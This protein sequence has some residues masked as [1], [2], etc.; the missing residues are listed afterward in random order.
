MSKFPGLAKWTTPV[1]T[2]DEHP[3]ALDVIKRDHVSLRNKTVLVTGGSAGIGVETVRAFAY[4]G[5]RVFVLAR[6]VDKARQVLDKI[7]AEFPQHGGL[8]IIQG[9]LDS[10]ASVNDAANDFL[11]RSDQLHI[12]VNNA[13]IY[14]VPFALT[15]D[16]FESQL[17]IDHIAHHLLFKKLV[18][19]LIKSSTPQFQS[20]VIAVASLVHMWGGVDFDDINYTNGREYT[21]SG[22]YIQAKLANIWF[23]NYVERL[24]GD[25]GV[26]ALSLHP[27]L[28][29]TASVEAIPREAKIKMGMFNADGDYLFTNVGKDEEQGA[30]T[31]VWAATSPELEGKGALYLEDV[32]IAKPSVPG[33][34]AGYSPAAFDDAQAAKMWDWTEKAISKFVVA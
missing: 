10:L 27:G 34:M 21:P 1:M 16:G 9:E 12:L 4:A 19:L 24:Y 2:H 31:T 28:I 8:E 26:H 20:R 18:P 32:A 3:T 15:K 5:A 30:A 22:A 29:T 14:Q 13:G 23:A 17:A 33:V 7:S 25:Q 11:K 6:S